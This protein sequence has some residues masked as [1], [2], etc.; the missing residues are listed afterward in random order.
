[1]EN[2]DRKFKKAS[3]AIFSILLIE[4]LLIIVFINI[5]VN[6]LGSTMHQDNSIQ[7]NVEI[8]NFRQEIPSIDKNGLKDINFSVYD[9]IWLNNQNDIKIPEI[10]HANIRD[11]SVKKEF[12]KKDEIYQIQFILDIPELKQTYQVQHLYSTTKSYNGN[13]PIKY[14]TM[15]YC[16]EESQMAY[17]EQNCNDRYAGQAKQII[18][19]FDFE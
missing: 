11:G 5:I 2:T 16:P 1:M 18:E 9:A 6:L 13:L 10:I 12:F 8:S 15:V 3:P 14:R 7:Y 4:I 19:D 17:Q